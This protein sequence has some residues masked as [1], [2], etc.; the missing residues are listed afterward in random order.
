MFRLLVVVCLLVAMTACNNKKEES[1]AP[2]PAQGEKKAEPENEKAEPAPSPQ[3]E[4]APAAASIPEKVQPSSEQPSPESAPIAAE[5]VKAPPVSPA[6]E[7]GVPSEPSQVQ[8][9]VPAPAAAA[10]GESKPQPLPAQG[11]DLAAARRDKIYE[12]YRLGA[13]DKQEDQEQIHS[14]VA[15]S[16][17]DSFI[18]ATAIRAMDPKR[19]DSLIPLLKQLADEEELAISSEAVILLYRW[20]EKEFAGPRLSQLTGKGIGIRRVFFIGLKDGVYQYQPE[21]EDHLR[22]ALKMP[23]DHVRLDAALGLL[24]LGVSSEALAVFKDSIS[25][26]KNL[27]IR[28]T[29]IS[30]LATAK[31]NPEVK[32]LLQ[33]A[34]RDID[35]QVAERAQMILNSGK[36]S[37]A[38]PVTNPVP[39]Q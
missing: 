21:A 39:V 15:D 9:E 4:A 25:S 10:V 19:E 1:Q 8:Q 11:V 14:M 30:Y 31:E 5:E 17:L 36:L 16:N 7:A 38:A 3:V 13:S 27:G 6:V 12:I 28:L 34:S 2:A 29:A 18:R 22:A 24:H 26:T 32:E 20:G 33:L 37:P 23:Q 35:P